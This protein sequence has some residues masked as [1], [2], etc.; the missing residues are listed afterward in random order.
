MMLIGY[1]RVSTNDQRLDLQLNAL[2]ALGCKKIYQDQISGLKKDRPGLQQ[3]LEQL[4]E[5]D[6]FV[7]WKLDRLGRSVKDLISFVETLEKQQV[8]FK[9]LTE[10][11]DTTTSQGR[12]IFN[13]M[14]SLAQMERDLVAERTRAGLTAAKAKGRIGGR[15]RLMTKS[16]IESARSLLTSGIPAKDVARDLG[17]SVPT[18][19]KWVPAG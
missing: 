17:V 1:A 16:K 19:Y 13:I 10:Q 14:A 15:R 18:L 7:I 9:S 4:R 3:A 12:F 11:I 8:N 6:V 5:G 2:E